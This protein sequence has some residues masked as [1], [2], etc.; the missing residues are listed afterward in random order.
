MKR[1]AIV[2]LAAASAVSAYGDSPAYQSSVI[3]RGVTVRSPVTYGRAYGTR[4]ATVTPRTFNVNV[5][6]MEPPRDDGRKLR[7]GHRHPVVVAPTYPVGYYNGYY[8]NNDL[9]EAEWAK[10]RLMEEE[11]RLKEEQAKIENEARLAEIEVQREHLFRRDQ[12]TSWDRAVAMYPAL[13]D[14]TSKI[15]IWYDHLLKR[16]VENT[17]RW[18]VPVRAPELDMADYPEIFAHRAAAEVGVVALPIPLPQTVAVTKETVVAPS[19]SA[20][21]TV[22]EEIP[23]SK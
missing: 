4:V 12:K 9:A 19:S 3:S 20:E 7:L 10:V 6:P 13:V 1:M 15:R 23:A 8:G 2:I 18:G 22:G 17:D 11:L 21:V 5:Q 16:A 14:P